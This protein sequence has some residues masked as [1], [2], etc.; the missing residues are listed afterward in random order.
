MARAKPTSSHLPSGVSAR[1]MPKLTPGFHTMVS[2]KNGSTRI[3][4]LAGRCATSRI[5]YLD[6]WS[7]TTTAVAT[8]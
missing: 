2:W 6:S 7:S 1:S 8:A 4:D 3:G 5:Q